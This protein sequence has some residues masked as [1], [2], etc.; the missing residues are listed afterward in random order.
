MLCIDNTSMDIYFN[1]ATEEYLL[2]KYRDD[3]FMLWQSKNAVVVG[4]HQKIEAEV[5]MDFIHEKG[6]NI[7][8]RYSGGGSVYQDL[9]NINLTFIKNTNRIDFNEY[10]Q[11]TLNFLS[12]V[13]I[14]AQTDARLGIYINRLKISGSAQS[15]YKDRMMYHCTLLY[16]TDLE[17]LV[18][19]LN[20]N[21]KI[22][23]IADKF[24]YGHGVK[25]VKSDVT[26]ISKHLKNPSD[27][28]DFKKLILTYFT[29]LSPKNQLY[30]LK[31]ED[32]EA[33]HLLKNEKYILN[34]WI[35][36]ISS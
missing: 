21:P 31:P 6:I 7:A 5:N 13:G 1:L 11:H 4:K 33:I 27:I 20:G 3:I 35:M 28:I 24:K 8:R 10:L 26:N 18:A 36:G 22:P 30:T 16:S 34:T 2:K 14:R 25:S 9:G 23:V 29:Q 17:S 15:I 12:S 19:S 32:I